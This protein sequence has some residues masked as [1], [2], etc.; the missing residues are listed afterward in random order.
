MIYTFTVISI[1][2]RFVATLLMGQY[3]YHKH[4]RLYKPSGLGTMQEEKVVENL[5]DDDNNDEVEAT[6]TG[7]KMSRR[8]HEM[9]D[10][11]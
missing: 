5:D 1:S 8:D 11:G 4:V 3:F 2:I 7:M 6:E 10:H 9:K